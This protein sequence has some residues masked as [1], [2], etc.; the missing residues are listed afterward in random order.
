MVADGDEQAPPPGVDT[1]Q[2]LGARLVTRHLLDLGHR[3]RL[4][5]AGP[6]TPSP[7]AA[8]RSPGTRT[9]KEAG[10][11]TPPVLYGD[12]SADSGYA[13][14]RELAARPE[15]TAVFAA[16]DQMALGVMR[17]LPRRDARCRTT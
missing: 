15:V 17:A 8:G 16:N 5:L 12:W 6:R 2:A 11:A 4:A 13:A 9:L 14:G 3:T 1:D 7:R 10:A